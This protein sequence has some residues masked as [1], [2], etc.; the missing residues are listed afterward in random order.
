MQGWRGGEADLHRIEVV[1][2]AAVFGDVVVVTAETQLGVG[3]LAVEQVAAVTFIDHDAVVLIHCGGRPILADIKNALHHA[4]H[5]S[6][7]HGGVGI[8]LLLVQLLDAKNIGEG[9]E[10]LHTRVLERV[11]GLFAKRGPVHQLYPGA[12]RLQAYHWPPL[13][14]VVSMRSSSSPS[15]CR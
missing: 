13:G 6:D 4:L 9:L 7:V 15:S 8:G 11:G 2:H 1:E 12:Q 3:Q 5:S 10:A 14:W